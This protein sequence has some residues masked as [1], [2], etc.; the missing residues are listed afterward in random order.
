MSYG[1]TAPKK[2]GSRKI[3]AATTKHGLFS[4]TPPL[5]ET[6]RPS[7][8]RNAQAEGAPGKRKSRRASRTAEIQKTFFSIYPIL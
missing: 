2:H 6:E 8:A 1:H 4:I 3:K 7:S 5:T